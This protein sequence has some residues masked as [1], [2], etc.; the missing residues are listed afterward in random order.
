M[1]FTL[2]AVLGSWNCASASEVS[3]CRVPT[4][5]AWMGHVFILHSQQQH[6]HHF[7]LMPAR[8][9]TIKFHL[10][11]PKLSKCCTFTLMQQRSE[12]GPKEGRGGIGD[13]ALTLCTNPVPIVQNNP[14][15]IVQNNPIP[16][17][18]NNPSIPGH[19]E[20]P[21]AT[22][23]LPH[24]AHCT[25]LPHTRCLWSRARS[26]WNATAGFVTHPEGLSIVQSLGWENATHSRGS[27]MAGQW[28]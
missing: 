9:T 7:L 11:K 20:A 3:K 25:S 1:S 27:R 13:S 16:I 21:V 22:R 24:F 28:E 12:P 6:P 19:V 18:Q 23:Q 14:V 15:P 2:S 17:V 5:C 4:K 8:E 10:S 26:L